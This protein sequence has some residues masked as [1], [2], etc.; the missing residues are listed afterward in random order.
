MKN[1]QRQEIRAHIEI[2]T[3]QVHDLLHGPD[4]EV[5]G[6]KAE[7]MRVVLDIPKAW[8]HLAAWL[9]LT[10]RE[11]N[12]SGHTFSDV[13]VPL[14]WE[15]KRRWAKV[16]FWRMINNQM[17][18]DLHF[19]CVGAHPYCSPPKKDKPPTKARLSDDDIPF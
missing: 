15:N 12:Y 13:N 1:Q 5:D 2:L 11:R 9:E 14:G 6:S 19:L 8:I 3:D 18:D 17:H 16:F 7:T 4:G 10:A